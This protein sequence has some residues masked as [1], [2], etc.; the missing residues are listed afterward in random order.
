[1]RARFLVLLVAV[2][3][4]A[5]QNASALTLEREV[6]IDPARVS[7]SIA[8]GVASVEVRGA[9]RES[10]AG[11]PDLPWISERVDLP[12]GMKLTRVEVLGAET[13]PMA[14]GVRVLPALSAKTGAVPGERSLADA[15]VFASPSF[16]PEVLALPGIQG[17]L[18]G[19]NVAYLRIAPSRWNPQT[20]ALERVTS[21]K[22]RLTMEEGAAPAVVRARLV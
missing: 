8:N 16:Q 3:S 18:R 20:G 5:A 13:Q 6:R 21:L 4:A 12:A 1:M 19:R 22:L 17:S 14:D 15:A 2:V 9:T 11:R 7:V 10:G